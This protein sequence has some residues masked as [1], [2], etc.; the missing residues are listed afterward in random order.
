M[1]RKLPRLYSTLAD[2]FHLLTAPEEYA[3][4]A[5]V[6][7]GMLRSLM[8]S[9]PRTVLELGSGGGNNASHMKAHFKLTLTDIS[10]E[11]LAVSRSIN[12]ECEHVQGDMRQLRL[13]RQFDAVFAHDALDYL[14]TLDDL[15]RMA[16]T[17][18]AHCRPGGAVLLVPDCVRETFN[19]ATEHGGHDGPQRALRYLEWSWDPDP[20]DLTYHSEMVYLM[21]QTDGTVQVEHEQH[22]LG[23]FSRADWLAALTQAGFHARSIPFDLSSM[24]PGSLEA[25]AG[26]K[27]ASE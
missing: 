22:L 8:T 11:M 24:Q 17:A 1:A 9:A 19:P 13:G 6:Y 18:W 16:Q 26:V 2:W 27:P 14:V 25:F 3:E 5:S 15:A 10:P 23:L 12:P 21:R 4:E 20:S 7:T